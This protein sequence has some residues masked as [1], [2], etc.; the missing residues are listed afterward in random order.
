MLLGIAGIQPRKNPY[1]CLQQHREYIF[2]SFKYRIIEKTH[3]DFQEFFKHS[4][5]QSLETLDRKLLVTELSSNCSLIVMPPTLSSISYSND[6]PASV[7]N[8]NPPGAR[9][10]Y[11][12]SC[13]L[14]HHCLQCVR[15]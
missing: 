2:S 3:W 4:K 8:T 6:Y 7:L 13:I 15:R 1:A 11:K 12:S 9:T 14:L 10:L 5:I